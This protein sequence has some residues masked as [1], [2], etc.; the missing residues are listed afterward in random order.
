M[1][2]SRRKKG[3]EGPLWE[4]IAMIGIIVTFAVLIL[5]IAGGPFGALFS[6]LCEHFP[7]ICGEPSPIEKEHYIKA[8]NSFKALT[9]AVESVGTGMF[10]C[11]EELADPAALNQLREQ[12][13][14]NNYNEVGPVVECE[15][16]FK[17]GYLMGGDCYSIEDI[18]V[19]A[20]DKKSA[21][22]HCQE[23]YDSKQMNVMAFEDCITEGE[24]D[25]DECRVRNLQF[26]QTVSSAEKW[27]IYYGD[28]K[29]M[30]Y[31]QVFPLMR[32]TWSY[33]P[34]WKTHAAIS[35]ISIIPMTKLVG[36]VGSGLKT[37]GMEAVKKGANVVI[38]RVGGTKVLATIG[39]RAA[40]KEA[41]KK[42][43]KDILI[44]RFSGRGL[45]RIATKAG[46]IE[47]A[48]HA[49]A[50]LEKSML[51]KYEPHGNAMILKSPYD[52]PL[53]IE[54]PEDMKGMPVMVSWKPGVVPWRIESANLVSPCFVHD[55]VI[56]K[57]RME[58]KQEYIYRAKTG[59]VYCGGPHWD[60]GGNEPECNLADYTRSDNPYLTDMETIMQTPVEE[61]IQHLQ[62]IGTKIWE[63][64]IEVKENVQEM[65]NAFDIK[66]VGIEFPKNDPEEYKGVKIKVRVNGRD[67]Y[68]DDSDDD[69]YFDAYS[70]RN[71][72][73]DTVNVLFN[74]WSSNHPSTDGEHNYCLDTRSWIDD[75]K[76]WGGMGV[77]TVGSIAVL[78]ATG[79]Q[80]GWIAPLLGKGAL[81]A[82]GA[83][84]GAGTGLEIAGAYG[85]YKQHW[86]GRRY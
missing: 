9:C 30:V 80:A 38:R 24:T 56:E 10:M 6:S 50:A 40:A 41:M 16:D 1:I 84:A 52:E 2:A 81:I 18:H 74:D 14:D 78:I 60:K 31:Y 15:R 65:E 64:K 86:P 4:V 49:A 7:G 13:D 83:A 21:K 51:A 53:V 35:I 26:P 47:G 23:T 36:V 42:G 33:K 3:V 73:T 22:E 19:K 25:L 76:M 28:P 68:F 72:V 44:K 85:D 58:C 55:A 37:V 17:C 62:D 46:I 12:G 82:G 67:V 69:G 48:V 27:V 54:L 5:L 39:S 20:F 66:W 61:E 75:M 57:K 34:D 29:F 70:M 71:C 63:Q 8:E 79:G 77:A 11:R 32:D 45:V 59:E 43:F